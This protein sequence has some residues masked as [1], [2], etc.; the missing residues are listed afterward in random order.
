MARRTITIQSIFEGVQA[1]KNFGGESEFLAS[2]GI[3]PDMPIT[4][5][6]TDLQPS[7]FIRPVNYAA[8]SS[9]EIDAAPIAIITEPKS[10]MTWVVLTNGK[11]RAYT[12]ALTSAASSSIGQVT[13]SS[14]SGAFYYNN[15]IFITGTGTAFDDM[16]AVG[17]LNTLPFDGQTGNFTAGLVVTGATSGA[18]ATIV[19]QVDAGATGT[20]TLE[21]ISGIFA[22][23]ET[24][25]D[26]SIGS[27]AVNRTFVSLITNAVWSGSLLGSQ[28]TAMVNTVY[29]TYLQSTKYLNHFGFAHTN[30]A[31]YVLD[32]KQGL[33][34]KHK[35]QT[36]R[37]TN[38]GDTN[39]GSTYGSVGALSLPRNYLP[40]VACSFGTDIAVASTKT[41]SSTTNQGNAILSLWNAADELFYRHIPLPD[42]LCAWIR[43]INGNL[44]GLSGSLSGGTRLFRYVGGDA[45]ETLKIIEDSQP[46]MQYGADFIG[47]RIVW[48]C[49]T[50]LPY[51]S[52]GLLAYGSK[53]D[54]FPKG[55]H[56]ILQGDFQ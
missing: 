24:I 32:F 25:T 6:A 55:L 14:A 54:L 48:G 50:T 27:A 3:D 16:A 21:N 31:A 8:F 22:D 44:Y 39:D 28:T 15:H 53:S 38:E 13:G 42:P 20:L 11:V 46:P 12:T 4:D 34:Y 56:N 36:T 49:N 1:S 47:N 33:G 45:I 37:T 2:I 51:I 23:N 5:A 17:P 43:Y 52:S 7:G 18:T 29:P 40:F 19:S 35:I 10:N 41:I 9:T 26:T 30:G